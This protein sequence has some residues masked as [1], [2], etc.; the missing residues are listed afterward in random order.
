MI[1]GEGVGLRL[2]VAEDLPLLQKWGQDPTTQLMFYSPFF[3]S[4]TA[5][6]AWY[7]AL[8]QDPNR[9]R[10]IVERIADRTSIGMIGLE[11]IQYRSQ[12]AELAGLVI[13]AA[14]RRWGWGGKALKTLVHYAFEDL[15]LNRLFTR[16]YA[17]NLA[18]LRVA[19]KAGLVREGAMREAIYHNWGFEDLVYMSILRE[20]WNH[21]ELGSRTGE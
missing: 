11:H 3:M 21:G 20:E 10:F 18:G 16:I 8:V 7:R 19:E 17:S 12:E 5:L 14:E 9:L 1:C 13:D 4:S 2:V 15:N 6:Q